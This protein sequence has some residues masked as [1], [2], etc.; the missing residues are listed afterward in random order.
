MPKIEKRWGQGFYLPDG[1]DYE[2]AA[3]SGTYF[4]FDINNELI[5]KKTPISRVF[6]KSNVGPS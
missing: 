1:V 5:N 4:G 2:Y 6:V 3:R